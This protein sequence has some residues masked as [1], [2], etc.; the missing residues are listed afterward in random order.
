MEQTKPYSFEKLNEVSLSK[1]LR[2]DGVEIKGIQAVEI[3]S[4]VSNVSQIEI[5]FIGKIKGLDDFSTRQ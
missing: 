4:D 5:R 2:I 1:R 3:K